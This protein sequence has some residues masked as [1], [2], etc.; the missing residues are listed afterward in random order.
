MGGIESIGVGIGLISGFIG[1]VSGVLVAYTM[2]RKEGRDSNAE[3]DRESD[4]VID[5]KD[6]RIRD[7]AARVDELQEAIN[8]LRCEIAELR[9]TVDEYGCWNGPTCKRRRPLGGPKPEPESA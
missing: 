8:A 5:L 4:R 6:T 1:V 3:D 9:Q 7:L 2:L